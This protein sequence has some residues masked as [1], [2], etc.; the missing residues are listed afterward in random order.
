MGPSWWTGHAPFPNTANKE[1]LSYGPGWVGGGHLDEPP[2]RLFSAALASVGRDGP[3]DRIR[4]DGRRSPKNPEE[5]V[6]MAQGPSACLDTRD[7]LR[8][9]RNSGEALAAVSPSSV[10]VRLPYGRNGG[11]A[12]R[13]RQLAETGSVGC[14]V[15]ASLA[16][17]P[18]IA[19]PRSRQPEPGGARARRYRRNS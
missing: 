17:P 15:S 4:R 2:Q 13:P 6:A 11:S 1:L 7:Q 9:P 8:V 10:R 14:V 3:N 16:E 18:P 19:D 5:P 12:G